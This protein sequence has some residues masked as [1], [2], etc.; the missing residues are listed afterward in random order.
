MIYPKLVHLTDDAQAYKSADNQY[1]LVANIGGTLR[2]L[3][4][5]AMFTKLVKSTLTV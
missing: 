2:K 5:S 3:K 1:V 4:H